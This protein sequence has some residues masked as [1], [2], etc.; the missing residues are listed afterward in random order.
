MADKQTWHFSGAQQTAPRAPR[1][2]FS[3]FSYAARHT[4]ANLL[5]QAAQA[6]AREKL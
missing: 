4:Q 3:A 1:P 2:E 6:P 5:L